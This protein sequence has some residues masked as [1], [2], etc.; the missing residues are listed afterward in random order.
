MS[1]R[2]PSRPRGTEPLSDAEGGAREGGAR[3]GGA[4]L[5][6]PVRGPDI[7]GEGACRRICF[8]GAG[9]KQ[10]ARKSHQGATKPTRILSSRVLGK[11][12][13]GFVGTGPLPLPPKDVCLFPGRHPS[14]G[15]SGGQVGAFSCHA[16][17]QGSH[18]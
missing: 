16:L 3:E 10:R 12:E 5:G 2:G 1:D 4:S 11:R 6:L 8:C 7:P 13:D 14:S 17:D 9:Q 18:I 15:L